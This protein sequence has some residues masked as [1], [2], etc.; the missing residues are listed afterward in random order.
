MRG[1]QA[2]VK[3]SFVVTESLSR[4]IAVKSRRING[5]VINPAS[6]YKAGTRSK[7]S[8]SSSSVATVFTIDTARAQRSNLYGDMALIATTLFLAPFPGC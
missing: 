8:D 5:S 7:S 2:T 1:N 6:N 3:Q 4:R